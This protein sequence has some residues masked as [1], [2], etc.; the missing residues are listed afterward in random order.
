ML[1]ADFHKRI[2]VV[3]LDPQTNSTIMLIGEDN[4]KALN[5]QGNNLHSFFKAAL[6]EPRR[7]P[8]RCHYVTKT[9]FLGVRSTYL[10]DW[11]A[12]PAKTAQKHKKTSHF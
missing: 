12:N 6:D 7:I 5:D 9:L 3:D 11:F 1:A 10:P 8:Q 4:W 2:L